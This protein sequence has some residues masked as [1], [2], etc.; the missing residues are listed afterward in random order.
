VQSA[1]AQIRYIPTL[2][3]FKKGT[4]VFNQAGLCRRRRSRIWCN[5]SRHS[6]SRQPGPDKPSK[7]DSMN[8]AGFAGDSVD[9]SEQLT[10][11][12]IGIT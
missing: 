10:L 4:L 9:G 6:T 1:A 5:K 7:P 8:R 3:A 2:M 11:E 12:L